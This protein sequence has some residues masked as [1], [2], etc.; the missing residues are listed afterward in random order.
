MNVL[1]YIFNKYKGKAVGVISGL[2]FSI[3]VLTVGIWKTLF[4]LLFVGIG[5]YIG[6]KFDKGESFLEFLDRILP[7][8]TQ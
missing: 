7:R 1:I 6:D 2:I 4:I 8:G 3:L 5:Y